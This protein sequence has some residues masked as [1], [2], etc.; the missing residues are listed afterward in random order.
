MVQCTD[1]VR[2]NAQE[3]YEREATPEK[4]ARHVLAKDLFDY[5][6]LKRGEDEDMDTLQPKTIAISHTSLSTY[7]TCPKQY[8]AKYITKEVKFT[9]TEATIYG[10][11]MHTAMEFRLRDKASLPEEFLTLEP[12]AAA[13]EAIKGALMVERELAITAALDTTTFFGSNV[14]LRGKGDAM[15]FN[16][17]TGRLTIFDWKTGKP[18]KEM[19]QLKIMAV[20]GFYNIPGVK[21]VRVA[22]V[23]TKTGDVDRE[24]FTAAQIPELVAELRQETNRLEVAHEKNLFPPQPN[25]LCKSYCSVVSCQFAGKGRYG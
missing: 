8:H 21:S 16:A 19:Q 4:A 7:Q 3:R 15:I 12:L 25:G 24:D 13:T 14:W 11:R 9:Q 10:N 20:A 2:V 23:Y 17:E 22:F 18:K 1:P 6:A 5:V